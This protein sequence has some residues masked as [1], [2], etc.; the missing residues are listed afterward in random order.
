MTP[1]CL[2]SCVKNINAGNEIKLKNWLLFQPVFK[3]LFID[4]MKFPKLTGDK[5]ATWEVIKM[6]H[7]Y[8]LLNSNY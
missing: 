7:V 6:R 4:D 8:H 1:F 3:E 5:N 2:V